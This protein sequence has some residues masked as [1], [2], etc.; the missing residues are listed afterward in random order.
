MKTICALLFASLIVLPGCY[1]LSGSHG[2]KMA[3]PGVDASED[4]TPEEASFASVAVSEDGAAVF[5]RPDASSVV[6][7]RLAAG[8]ELKAL[9]RRG[10]YV[11]VGTEAEGPL[12]YVLLRAIEGTSEIEGAQ[13]PGNAQQEAPRARKLP[14]R[15]RPG[16]EGYK[17]PAT[18]TLVSILVPGGGQFYAGR[19]VKGA[20]LLITSI[21][22]PLVASQ[23]V[24]NDLE[25]C[26]SSRSG[27]DADDSLGAL[28]VGIG[29]GTAAW[30]IG[31]VSASGDAK[32][33]NQKESLLKESLLRGASIE[34]AAI[35]GP[36]GGSVKPGLQLS[37]RF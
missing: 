6:V 34:P 8:E 28:Y 17:D 12:G 32:K 3:N 18:A 36:G 4:S 31:V 14:L 13:T 21:A 29:V 37:Y 23:V 30:L 11:R 27:C 2:S 1:T 35:G 19:S 10:G 15:L 7:T 25:N 24:A 16:M 33:A 22:A 26:A 20:G 5:Q 9:G